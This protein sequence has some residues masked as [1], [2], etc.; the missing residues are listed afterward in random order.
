[1]KVMNKNANLKKLLNGEKIIKISGAHDGLSAKI[2][3]RNGFDAVWASGFGIS[4][5]QTVPDA[6]ILSMKEFL[7]AADIMNQS[8][9]IPIIADCDSGYGNIHNV[10]HMIKKYESTGISGV[11]IEDKV[12]PKINSFSKNKQQLVSIDEFCNK[13]KAAKDAQVDPNFVVI[14]RVES[15][16][17][18]ETMENALIRAKHYA[19]AGAD[20]ILI[21]SKKSTPNEIFEFCNMWDDRKPLVVVPTKYPDVDLQTLEKYGIKAAIFANQALRA[22]VKITDYVLSKISQQ[23]TSINVE[24]EISSVQEIFELQNMSQFKENNETYSN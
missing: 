15:L 13:I 8:T 22:S 17:A 11:C 12:F 5:T 19:D 10:I 23:G 7:D 21:H 20:A 18:G 3:E 1:M 16:I 14:A 24:E 4:A 9:N 2:S 6:S